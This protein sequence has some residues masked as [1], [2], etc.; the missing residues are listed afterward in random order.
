MT[1]TGDYPKL[2]VKVQP[3]FFIRQSTSPNSS[4]GPTRNVKVQ[5]MFAYSLM[6]PIINRG[7]HLNMNHLCSKAPN[8]I[9]CKWKHYERNREGG[10]STHCD[11]PSPKIGKML[12]NECQRLSIP[13]DTDTYQ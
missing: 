3:W 9:S 6:I 7:T 2:T 5:E 1:E 12:H 10:E 4:Q 8:R 11:A 13:T